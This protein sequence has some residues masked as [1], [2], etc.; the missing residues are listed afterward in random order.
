M[1]LKAGKGVQGSVFRGDA[2]CAS[3]KTGRMSAEAHIAEPGKKVPA[4]VGAPDKMAKWGHPPV[5]GKPR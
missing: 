1:R 3:A 4:R 2:L 5:K